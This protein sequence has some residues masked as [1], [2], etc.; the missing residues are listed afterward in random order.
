MFGIFFCNLYFVKY[1]CTLFGLFST[2]LGKD[3]TV[4]NQSESRNFFM[5][6]IILY[7]ILYCI[8]LYCITLYC[9]YCI[10][11]YCIVWLILFKPYSDIPTPPGN[12][13]TRTETYQE[14]VTTYI[15][16]DTFA[17]GSWLDTSKKEMPQLS[18]VALTRLKIQG[19]VEFG[20]QETAEDFE[21]Q[22][23]EMIERNR[24]RDVFQD[25]SCERV[26]AGL[27]KRI[28][29]YVDLRLRPYWMKERYYW[30]ATLLFLTWPFR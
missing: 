5:C 28:S 25:F 27:E 10:V 9:M 11:L 13:Q 19:T 23:S 30:L 26:I 20:D 12:L 24:H 1:F 16:H 15:D 8:A 14:K 6:I 3:C 4:F 17:F 7:Y 18:T 29:A 21:R 22:K 2:L